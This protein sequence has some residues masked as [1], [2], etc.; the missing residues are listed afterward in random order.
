MAWRFRAAP[1][2]RQH[3][4]YEQVE[5]AWPVHGSILITN[6]IIHAVAG[7]SRFT[8]GGMR[9]LRIDPFRGA[10]ISEKVLDERRASDG[11]PLQENFNE[12]FRR[13]KQATKD[14]KQVALMT[15]NDV[16]L[17]DILTMDG[18]AVFMRG[19]PLRFQDGQQE[20]RRNARLRVPWGLVASDWSHRTGWRYAN[21]PRSRI[22][23]FNKTGDV[24]GFGFSIRYQTLLKPFEHYL[25]GKSLSPGRATDLWP[26]QE[27][28][29]LVRAMILAGDKLIVAGPPDYKQYDE[30]AAYK[31]HGEDVFR[32]QIEQ[33]ADAWAGRKGGILWLIETKSG[34]RLSEVPLDSPPVFD[35]M[36]S[37]SA[38]IYISTMDG[39]VVFLESR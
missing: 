22:L 23:V 13:W 30:P 24:F 33:Q 10:K 17:S 36:A 25:Y 14:G 16:G 8:D 7:R 35:G 5:S 1:C 18:E 21:S 32:Q 20:A 39:H 11:Q 12:Q 4:A 29:M 37:T 9:L 3:V 28:P 15:F 2:E 26:D 6:N 31:R 19:Y 27:V 38:G 34:A